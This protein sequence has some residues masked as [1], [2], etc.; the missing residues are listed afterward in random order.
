MPNVS[1]VTLARFASAF[2]ARE[3]SG[4]ELFRRA[5]LDPDEGPTM[6]VFASGEGEYLDALQFLS[7]FGAGLSLGARMTAAWVTLGGVGTFDLTIGAD[8]R[9][10]IDADILAGQSFTLTST[11][12]QTRLGWPASVAAS[13][14]GTYAAP[15]DWTRGLVRN[16]AGV[17]PPTVRLGRSGFGSTVIQL[18]WAQD[19][20]CLLRGSYAEDID[21]PA[22]DSLTQL[23]RAFFDEDIVWGVT[24]D[25]FVFWCAIG[26][27]EP[28]TWVSTTFR[29][30]LGFTGAEAVVY[31]NVGQQVSYCI[32]AKRL[33]GF[34]APSRPLIRCDR[35]VEGAGDHLRLADGSYT[36]S[37]HGTFRGWEVEARVDGPLDLGGDQTHGWGELLTRWAKVGR[38]LTVYQDGDSRRFRHPAEVSV[39]A[40]AYS[41]T[42]TSQLYA[43]RLVCATHPDTGRALA[44][45]WGG[46]R[47]RMR[48]PV[49]VVL[50]D[51]VGV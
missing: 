46:S 33:P 7:A 15:R 42:H 30:R 31:E 23:D 24:D 35:L 37:D 9:V 40:P 41:L 32:A 21:T 5:D 27:F 51:R 1:H 34:V 49:G 4:Q 48:A 6:P 11:P 25:G 16:G 19:V 43:G 17:G 22:H 13:P 3:W 44:L 36:T 2:N 26:E 39:D 12:T 45:G 18:P 47:Y 28:I 8:D 29:D 50:A 20:R 38:P 14:A 10:V